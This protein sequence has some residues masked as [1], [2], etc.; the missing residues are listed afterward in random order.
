M[1]R[2]TLGLAN[3]I[4]N[5]YGESKGVV[6]AYDSRYKSKEFCEETAKTLAAYGIKVYIFDSLRPTLEL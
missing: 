5:I 4:I 6:T 2:A 3:N 1:I